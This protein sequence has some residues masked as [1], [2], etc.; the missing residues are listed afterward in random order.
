H[1][2]LTIANCENAAGGFGVTPAVLKQLFAYGIDVL[3]SGNHIWDKR[4][5]ME[6]IESER[7]LLRPANYPPAQPGFGSFVAETAGGVPVAVLNLSGRVFMGSYDCPFRTA[8]ELVPALAEAARVIIVDMH[9]EATSEKQAM[10]YYLDGRVS[11]VIGTHTHV[12][13]A[14]E[15]ILPDGTAYITDVGMTGPVDSVI[16]V[17]KELALKRF[18]T[19]QPQKMETASGRTQFSA[20]LIEVDETAGRAVSIERLCLPGR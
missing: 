3:T 20:C 15:R 2:D 4:E 10:G 1:V 18:L 12:Q 11:A 17:V 5:V 13:T 19:L 16:G 6:V 14:D 9:G 7:R 8:D